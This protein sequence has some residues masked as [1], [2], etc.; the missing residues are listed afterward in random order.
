MRWEIFGESLQD[1]R[2]LQTLG[3]DR[4]D[5][6]LAS[7]RS[8]EAFPKYAAWRLKTKAALYRAK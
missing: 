5:R 2:L 1:Y 4:G 6:R 8:F 7:L 3:I